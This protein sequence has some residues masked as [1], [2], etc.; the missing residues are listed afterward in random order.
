AAALAHHHRRLAGEG[1]VA[2]AAHVLRQVH[3]QRRLA[4][5]SPAEQAKDLRAVLVPEPAGDG[6]QRRVL[7]ARPDRRH[8]AMVVRTPPTPSM[9]PS[10]TSPRPTAPTPA[11]VPVM[12]R[13]PGASATK[14]LRQAMVSG[15]DQIWSARSPRWRCSP[16]TARV[17]APRA[18]WP[19]AVAGAISPSGADW[20]NPLAMVQGRPCRL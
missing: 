6:D 11:G 9:A 17:M 14:A 19:M 18:G 2:D 8:Q 7:L 15:T 10:S 20:S 12:M 3:G 5:A 1:G 4:G 13:S 16:L